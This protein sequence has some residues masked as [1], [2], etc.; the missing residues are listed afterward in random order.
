[1]LVLWQISSYFWSYIEV[2]HWNQLK[3]FKKTLTCNHQWFFKSFKGII[4][5]QSGVPNAHFLMLIFC[6]FLDHESKTVEAK[7]V[8]FSKKLQN[9]E[10][11]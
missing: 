10:I 9:L 3:M 2:T 5:Q 1:M 4:N 11:E 7:A 6:Q 8:E